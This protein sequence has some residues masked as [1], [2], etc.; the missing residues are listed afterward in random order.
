MVVFKGFLFDCIYLR[1][2]ILK[3]GWDKENM[4]SKLF[5]DKSKLLY[6]K[7]SMKFLDKSQP[8]TYVPP[9]NCSHSDISNKREVSIMYK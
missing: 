5:N 7:N 8:F 6:F 4:A 1:R 9:G 2:K 3:I